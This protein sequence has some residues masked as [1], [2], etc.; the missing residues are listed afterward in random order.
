ML[1]YKNKKNVLIYGAGSAG[2]LLLASLENSPEMKMAGFLDD[3]HQF[4][5]QTILGQTVYNPLQIEKLIT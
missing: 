1:D 5:N 3:N 2:R 4:H